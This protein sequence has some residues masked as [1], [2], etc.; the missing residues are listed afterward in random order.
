MFTTSRTPTCRSC[1]PIPP[2]SP[3]SAKPGHRETAAAISL[4]L[5][6][7]QKLS[8]SLFSTSY[9]CL[10]G[11]RVITETTG[12]QCGLPAGAMPVSPTAVRRLHFASQDKG[13]HV[14]VAGGTHPSHEVVITCMGLRKRRA[15]R[16]GQCCCHASAFSPLCRTTTR[17]ALTPCG[18]HESWHSVP[19][20][21][22]LSGTHPYPCTDSNMRGI[23]EKSGAWSDLLTLADSR[24]CS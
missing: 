4:P 16:F 21:A 20:G 18:P 6:P 24:D 8:P 1:L 13:D 9:R 23:A 12:A 2:P 10:W 17:A 7:S 14:T 3:R 19:H 5:C 11:M 22:V 15:S